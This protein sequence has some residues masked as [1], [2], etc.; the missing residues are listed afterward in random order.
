MKPN[1][2]HHTEY[3]RSIGSFNFNNQQ[4]HGTSGAVTQPEVPG[5]RERGTSAGRTVSS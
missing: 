2:V 5:V 1:N 4:K 3:A